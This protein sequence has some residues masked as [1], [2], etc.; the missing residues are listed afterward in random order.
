MDVSKY[1]SLYLQETGE[2]LSG[3]ESGLLSLEKNPGDSS[4]LGNL[5]RHFHSI[6]GMSASMGYEPMTRLAHAQEDLL[7]KLRSGALANSEAVTTILLKC[8]DAMKE[9]AE[10]VK[11]DEPLDR[12]ITGTRDSLKQAAGG[13]AARAAAPAPVPAGPPPT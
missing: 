12:D 8:L 9:L 3:I 2:H 4:V 11:A 13:Q 1:K 6:K 7:D 10:R 5:F